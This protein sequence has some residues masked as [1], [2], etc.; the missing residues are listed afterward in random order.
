MCS[1]INTIIC[2]TPDSRLRDREC[3]ERFACISFSTSTSHV[4]VQSPARWKRGCGGARVSCRS[5]STRISRKKHRDKIWSLSWFQ[6]SSLTNTLY[7]HTRGE[8][9]TVCVGFNC[10]PLSLRRYQ[11]CWGTNYGGYHPRRPQVHPWTETPVFVL[12]CP[13]MMEEGKK[14]SPAQDSTNSLNKWCFWSL[15]SWDWHQM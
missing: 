15:T 13:L 14:N 9:H 7:W 11:L 2:L 1:A 5:T 10:S 6:L 3:N 4:R 8:T 12:W